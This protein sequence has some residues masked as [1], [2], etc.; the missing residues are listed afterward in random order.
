MMRLDWVGVS[1]GAK[2]YSSCDVHSALADPF[3][4][5]GLNMDTLRCDR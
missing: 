4:L 5:Q 3:M 1:Y 2:K